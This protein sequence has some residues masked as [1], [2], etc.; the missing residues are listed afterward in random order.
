MKNYEETLVEALSDLIFNKIIDDTINSLDYLIESKNVDKTKDQY[1][2]R[3][4]VETSKLDLIVSKFEHSGLQRFSSVPDSEKP[5]TAIK[6]V[7]TN[8]LQKKFNVAFV[9]IQHINKRE[10]YAII[11]ATIGMNPSDTNMGVYI[12]DTIGPEA[13]N[14]NFILL[15]VA[16]IAVPKPDQGFDTR[17]VVKTSAI[18]KPAAMSQRS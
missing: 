16:N 8:L 2:V 15:P 13:T 6:F 1:D 4:K 9:N 7:L 11:D 10:I 18:K 12:A 3:I 5:S 14:N 17:L